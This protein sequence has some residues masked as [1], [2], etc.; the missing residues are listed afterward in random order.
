MLVLDYLKNKED[1]TKRLEVNTFLKQFILIHQDEISFLGLKINKTNLTR[2]QR[3]Y[4]ENGKYG[5]I[6]K[7][8]NIKGKS[9]KIPTWVNEFVESKFFNKRGNIT[10]KN[11]YDL[12][13]AKAFQNG[14]ITLEEY[15]RTQ[16]ER[17]GIISYNRV[18]EIIRELKETAKYKYLINPDAFKNSIL[19]DLVTWEKSIIC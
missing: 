14:S 1:I 17:G 8:G 12:V 2:W 4:K 11:L 10:A 5:F 19:F 9:F 13:N 18:K 16:K 7:S 15:K 6:K 3:A